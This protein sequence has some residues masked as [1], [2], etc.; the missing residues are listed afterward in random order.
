[1]IDHNNE[2]G[3]QSARVDGD[4]YRLEQALRQRSGGSMRASMRDVWQIARQLYGFEGSYN[5]ATEIIA[6]CGRYAL[7]HDGLHKEVPMVTPNC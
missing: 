1:M 6:N 7:R 3:W 5:E 4:L 2:N